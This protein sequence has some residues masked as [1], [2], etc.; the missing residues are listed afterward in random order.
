MA[1]C[2]MAFT[3]DQYAAAPQKSFKVWIY[4]SGLEEHLFQSQKTFE[5]E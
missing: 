3:K 1:G 4:L 2:Q 5:L